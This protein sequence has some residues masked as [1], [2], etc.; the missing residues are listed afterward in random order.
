MCWKDL[1]VLKWLSWYEMMFL[2]WQDLN[3]LKWLSWYKTMFRCW[4]HFDVLTWLTW[5]EIIDDLKCE[6][7]AAIM[8]TMKFK[9]RTC[10]CKISIKWSNDILNDT[11]PTHILWIEG[12]NV[13]QQSYTLWNSPYAHTVNWRSKC[14]ATIIHTMELTLRTYCE[15]KV[16]MSCNNHT[17]YETH[18]THIL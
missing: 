13:M 9:P 1:D 8:H 12:L 7:T 17:H 14:N 16:W 3:V 6:P 2:C 4:L 18:P 15:L 11:H 10:K 5:V